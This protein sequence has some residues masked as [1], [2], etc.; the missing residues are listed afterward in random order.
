MQVFATGSKLILDGKP[1]MVGIAVDITARKQAE[2]ETLR[3]RTELAHLSRVTMPGELSGSMAHELNQPLTAILSNAQAAIRFLAHDQADLDEVAA[4]S[5]TTSWSRITGPAKSFAACACCFKKGEV[6]QQPLD[7]NDVVQEVLKL[8]RSDLVNQ[9]VIA[10]TELGRLPAVGQRQPGAAP[11]GSLLE[12]GDELPADAM[13]D[14]APADRQL[15]VRTEL[16]ADNNV[17]VSVFDRGMGLT[18]ANLEKVFMPS[19]PPSRTAWAWGLSVCRTIITSHG[20]N[21]WAA[22][23]EVRGA[24]FH[25]AIP[26]LEDAGEW[27]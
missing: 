9:N 10:H 26:A 8:V 17:R 27:R 23:G 4:T 12:S 21:L 19:T 24:A 5:S 22:N 18:P 14:N 7:L 2:A 20:G 15:L 25:F 6:Q 13:H 1:H 3:Q 16:C 11:A